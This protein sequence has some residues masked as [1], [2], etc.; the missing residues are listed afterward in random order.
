MKRWLAMFMTMVMTM[1][2]LSVP[3]YAGEPTETVAEDG[4]EDAAVQAD[5]EEAVVTAEETVKPTLNTE[6]EETVSEV[7]GNDG[8]YLVDEQM[9]ADYGE[10][11]SV[12][13]V[14]GY[15]CARVDVDGWE[16]PAD[17][18]IIY[19]RAGE[20]DL[21]KNAYSISSGNIMADGYSFSPVYRS[22]QT[23]KLEPDQDY[24]YRLALYVTEGNEGVYHFLTKPADFRVKGELEKGKSRLKIAKVTFDGAEKEAPDGDY[25]Y[26]AAKI[27]VS[28]ENPLNE[29][30]DPESIIIVN[31]GQETT[32]GIIPETQRLTH[33]LNNYDSNDYTF[34]VKL[35]SPYKL[36]KE[37]YVRAYYGDGNGYYDEG[38]DSWISRETNSERKG[39]VL[40]ARDIEDMGEPL[41]EVHAEDTEDTA[42]VLISEIKPRYDVDW[43][44]TYIYY[45]KKGD[46]NWIENRAFSYSNMCMHTVSGLDEE[47][48]YE[49]Y[50][51]LK[52]DGRDVVLKS[53]GSKED[54][55]EFTTGEIKNLEAEDFKDKAFYEYLCSQYGYSITSRQLQAFTELYLPENTY[56]GVTT[57]EDIPKYMPYLKTLQVPYESVKDL[58]PLLQLDMLKRVT[59]CGN[60]IEELPDMTDVDWEYLDITGNLLK[61]ET[62]DEANMVNIASVASW[63][64]GTQKITAAGQQYTDGDKIPLRFSYEHGVNYRYYDA[65]VSIDGNKQK[66]TDVLRLRTTG[67]ENI[68]SYSQYRNEMLI[69]DLKEYFAGLETDK[70]INISIS[71]LNAA[72]QAVCSEDFKIR[73]I[74]ST[75]DIYQD[76]SNYMTMSLAHGYADDEQL[77]VALYQNGEKLVDGTN[78]YCYKGQQN[79][80]SSKNGDVVNLFDRDSLS[81]DMDFENLEAGDY[82][83]KIGDVF[84]P[85]KV[86]YK[87]YAEIQYTLT[88]KI[89][90]YD[91]SGDYLYVRLRGNRVDPD[92]IW[93][94]IT[95]GEKEYTEK[96]TA[97]KNGY[98]TWMYKV[99]K[100]DNW[101]EIEEADDDTAYD[102]AIRSAEGCLL[103]DNRYGSGRYVKYNYKGL[104][105]G[106]TYVKAGDLKSSPVAG[107]KSAYFNNRKNTLEL[108]FTQQ[109][110]NE[111]KVN[112][113]LYKNANKNKYMVYVD[114]YYASLEQAEEYEGEPV[115]IA[116]AEGTVKNGR[117]SMKLA[118]TDGKEFVPKLRAYKLRVTA[119]GYDSGIYRLYQDEYG[120]S[121]D[122]LVGTGD[123]D[124]SFIDGSFEM[125]LDNNYLRAGSDTLG[126]TA[127]QINGCRPDANR[128]FAVLT[129]AV[130]VYDDDDDWYYSYRSTGDKI[131]LTYNS[132]TAEYYVSEWKLNRP[133]EAG[134]YYITLEDKDGF[135]YG[136]ENDDEYGQ[137][138]LLCPLHVY[139]ADYSGMVIQKATAFWGYKDETHFDPGCA[140]VEATIPFI[141]DKLYTGEAAESFATENHLSLEVR[142]YNNR[143]LAEGVTVKAVE[144]DKNLFAF[145]VSGLDADAM[146]YYFRFTQ[147]GN[148]IENC[149]SEGFYEECGEAAAYGAAEEA[150]YEP[151]EEEEYIGYFTERY[152]Y[153]M[154]RYDEDNEPEYEVEY[155]GSSD[156]YYLRGSRR[157][158]IAPYTVSVY[159]LAD[160]E[161]P[162]LDTVTVTEKD[163]DGY[164]K[165][166]LKNVFKDLDKDAV[167]MIEIGMAYN[168]SFTYYE[169]FLDGWNRIGS[170]TKDGQQNKPQPDPEPVKPQPEPEPAP[171]PEPS[172]VPEDNPVEEQ[173][174]TGSFLLCFYVNGALYTTVSVK[175]GEA[176]TEMPK[177][178]AGIF[179]G[180]YENGKLWDPTAPVFKNMKLEARFAA[181]SPSENKTGVSALDAQVEIVEGEP[182]WLVKGQKFDL[183]EGEWESTDPKV[184]KVKKNAAEAKAEGSTILKRE[185]L[186]ITVYVRKPEMEKKKTLI[187]GAAKEKIGFTWTD[188]AN[189]EV[190][191]YSSDSDIVSVT[192]DGEVYGIGKGSA[193]VTAYVNGKGYSCKITVKEADKSKKDWTKEVILVPLQKDTLK[194]KGFSF[195]NA[196]WSSDTDPVAAEKLEKNEVFRDKVVSVTNKGKI[197]AIGSGT[198]HMTV[199]NNGQ[200]RKLTVTVAEPAVKIKH[201]NTGAKEKEGI[202]GIKGAIV[203]NVS[204]NKIARVDQ[205]GRIWADQAGNT[206]LTYKCGGFEYMMYLYVD[207]INFK[208]EKLY[209]TAN[210][211]GSGLRYRLNMKAESAFFLKK[212]NISQSVLFKSSKDSVVF[213]DE[214]GVVTARKKG[215]AN[216]TAKVNGRK[217]TIKVNVE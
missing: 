140:R 174:E 34:G 102:I 204:D 58:S 201:M 21:V 118:G 192:A 111:L 120:Y 48:Q 90:G 217:I 62:I 1:S 123:E 178:P 3:V 166:D 190:C 70:D 211:S 42:I 180:W 152:G 206:L 19:C 28:I 132:A 74:N 165:Y 169:G 49:Y 122:L 24:S 187:A 159:D 78:A 210:L 9:L 20:K 92:K 173:A 188:K 171:E 12:N 81:F 184:L 195:K 119:S 150:A 107:I 22:T 134:E 167:Y 99:R 129:T 162:L 84:Y 163:L 199:T 130:K 138:Y 216:L 95:D 39:V 73:F 94:V 86:H 202:Y 53:I 198:T 52:D 61:Q 29:F 80:Y 181:S 106:M 68:Y 10:S 50:C 88:G 16:G 164:A 157:A 143:Q 40:K 55:E 2:Q 141:A 131:E 151:E 11:L 77:S 85:G 121:D 207:E 215:K 38:L 98:N 35:G 114:D 8:E 158:G 146:A 32:E 56:L 72:G 23:Y 205:K 104:R 168:D 66:I 154:Y 149:H 108:A 36:E 37:V 69:P 112:V 139:A 27:T 31:K 103:K 209:G 5:A 214:A 127:K 208:G 30:V 125:K 65:E 194:L 47:T 109:T 197:T 71:V 135:H 191:W 203:W 93:P 200:S 105:G 156:H 17:L 76:S 79:N 160:L 26:G 161:D 83:L 41:L 144:A 172:D 97:V 155:L 183:P 185:N 4:G 116:S 136:C 193:T 100:T 75:G 212:E 170:Y 91:S 182:L 145:A 46:V 213:V 147:N 117:I 89:D 115:L 148:L 142:D 110:K 133:L 101:D 64:Q 126:F 67:T 113:S 196:T 6:V 14:P 18:Q 33:Y 25:G 176:V 153:R 45:R 82:D 137:E 96:V 128:L 7:A 179:L 54:P 57:L 177:D 15:Y 186:V 87:N 189:Y 60:D 51:V 59:L 44:S 63:G 13:I 175:E 124:Y 43:I